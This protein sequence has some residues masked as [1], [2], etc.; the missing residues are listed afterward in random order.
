M[1]NASVICNMKPNHLHSEITQEIIAGFFKVYNQLRYG[2]LEKVYE[3]ALIYEL[4]KIGIAH[5]NQVRSKSITK[6]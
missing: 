6:A 2:F 5:Q 4:K 3:N 1:I